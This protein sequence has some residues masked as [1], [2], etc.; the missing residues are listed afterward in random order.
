MRKTMHAR[1]SRFV[2]AALAVALVSPGLAARAAADPS[3][4]ELRETADRLLQ[5]WKK[6]RLADSF[7]RVSSALQRI[8][9]LAQLQASLDSLR[10]ELGDYVS[11]GD[12]AVAPQRIDDRPAFVLAAELRFERGK[13]VGTFAFLEERGMWRLRYVKIEQPAPAASADAAAV[14]SFAEE[15]VRAIG[16]DGLEAAVPL[17]PMKVRQ[18]YGDRKLREIFARTQQ[19]L[20]SYREHALSAPGAPI[21]EGCREVGGRARFEHGEA[22]LQLAVC[23]EGSGLQLLA[24]NVQP[25]MTPRVFERMARVDVARMLGGA[26]FELECPAALVPVG[27]EAT[28]RVRTGGRTRVAKVRRMEEGDIDVGELGR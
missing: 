2:A 15:V 6:G 1:R 27:A 7:G 20:G 23:P 17:F 26:D 18:E 3:E 21:A 4:R 5:D 10:T 9:T 11:T 24:I 16:R 25:R 22:A 19:V 28:C 12:V 13:A 8:V 14:S